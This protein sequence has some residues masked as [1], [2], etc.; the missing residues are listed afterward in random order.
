MY[1]GMMY[2]SLGEVNK[3]TVRRWASRISVPLFEKLVK[4]QQADISAQSTFMQEEKQRILDS[5]RL[6]FE[7]IKEEKDCLQVKDLALDGKDLIS[8]GMKPGKEIGEMLTGLLELVLE[9]PAQ[10]KREVLEQAVREKR[11]EL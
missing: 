11:G 9:D 6:L 3:K 1:T 8:L 4:I 2:A 10:N 7:E 5:T